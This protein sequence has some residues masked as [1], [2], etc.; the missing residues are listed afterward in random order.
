MI[1]LADET[2]FLLCSKKELES[3]FLVDQRSILFEKQPNCCFDVF[4]C[5]QTLVAIWP[6]CLLD[7]IRHH[8]CISDLCV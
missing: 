8:L 5:V 2:L 6:S 4:V 1:Q 3:K 7:D